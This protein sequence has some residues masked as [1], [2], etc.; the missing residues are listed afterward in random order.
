MNIW[1]EEGDDL[2]KISSVFGSAKSTQEAD[3]V[4]ILQVS[5]TAKEERGNYL[6][7]IEVLKFHRL[8]NIRWFYYKL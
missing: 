7:F 2:L 6:K 4:I 5:K 3:N 8:E 1:Q